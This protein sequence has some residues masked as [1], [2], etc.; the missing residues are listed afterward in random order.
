[1]S[2]RRSGCSAALFA[3]INSTSATSSHDGGTA[4]NENEPTSPYAKRAGTTNS[5]RSPTRIVR[6]HASSATWCFRRASRGGGGETRSEPSF[7][8]LSFPS[9]VSFV[10]SD[11]SFTA[12]SCASLVLV[13]SPRTSWCGSDSLRVL[14]TSA[15]VSLRC[16]MS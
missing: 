11:E 8:A 14:Q 5:A 15:C 2:A 16:H 6:K 3:P 4:G 1:M 13:A 12:A 9:D 7:S 10:P